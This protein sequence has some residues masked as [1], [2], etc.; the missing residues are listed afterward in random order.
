MKY[1]DERPI[2]FTDES[3]TENVLME[4]LNDTSF[5]LSSSIADYVNMGTKNDPFFLSP[6]KK[7][8]GKESS[9]YL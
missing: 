8:K 6:I 4:I 9:P 7:S 5:I 1:H 2:F 3:C